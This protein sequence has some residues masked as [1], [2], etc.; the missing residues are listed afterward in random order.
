[1]PPNKYPNYKYLPPSSSEG[2]TAQLLTSVRAAA[3]QDA[4]V[5]SASP[6]GRTAPPSLPH[7]NHAQVTCPSHGFLFDVIKCN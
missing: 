4:D 1:M 3:L 2:P 5:L 6:Q 7:G